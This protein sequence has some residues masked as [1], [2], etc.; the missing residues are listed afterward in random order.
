[1]NRLTAPPL[2]RRPW[3]AQAALLTPLGPARIAATAQ[4]LGG[5][6]FDDQAH[7]PG[8]LDAPED[9]G[10]RWLAQARDELAAY[11]R[12]AGAVDFSVPLDLGGS[13]FQAA[14]W[15]ALLRIPCGQRVTY[16]ALARQ[17]GRPGAVR[18]LGAAVGRNPVSILVPCHRVLGSDGSLT[19]YAGGLHRKRELL[20]REA[21]V[22][23]S[24]ERRL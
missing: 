8:P 15:A 4:G 14:V 24:P 11:W 18:A 2:A 16:G 6:W 13:V 23:V 12:H 3:I 17:I 5:F 10:Q 22:L 19:G 7:H 20:Q 9:P 21:D 1:M